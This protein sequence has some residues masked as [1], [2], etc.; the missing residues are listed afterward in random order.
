[1]IWGALLIPFLA[2]FV[3][4]RWYAH[5]MVWWEYLLP[6]AV[7]AMLIGVAGGVAEHS[8][9]T[10]TEYW[11]SA[12]TKAEYYEDW[13]E[14]IHRTCSETCC[15]DKDGKNCSTRYYD[16]S[17]VQYHSAYWE[18]QT[19]TGEELRIDEWQ[20]NRLVKRFGGARFEDLHR[21]YHTND[22]DK[23]VTTWPQDSATLEPVTT[24][25]TYENRVKAA[26]QSIF[27]FRRIAE[28]ERDSL[29]LFDYPPIRFRY[30][31]E[32]VLGDTTREARAANYRLKWWNAVLGPAKEARVSVL[33]FHDKPRTT[34]IQQEW[35]WA[36]GNMNEVVLCIGLDRARRVQWCHPMSWSTDEQLEAELRQYV[37]AQDTVDLVA[38]ADFLGPLVRRHFVRRDFHQ[39]DYLSIEPPGWAVV[40]VYFLTAL[41][42]TI[43]GAFAVGNEAVPQMNR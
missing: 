17:Y 28:K 9:V 39:F 30:H 25:H 14:Y 5:H 19:T 31:Q 18:L 12:V 34:G 4:W 26:D 6:L 36:G 13:N 37:E 38:V 41:A 29:G 11:G 3:L 10:S 2:A 20:Y 42:C 40:L 24:T 15:C 27:H 22:G 35:A 23:Y 16:C 32:A 1:M 33:V 8:M 43:T 7:S 21:H